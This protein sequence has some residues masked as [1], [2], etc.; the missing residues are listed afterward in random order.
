MT[1]DKPTIGHVSWSPDYDKDWMERQMEST[2]LQGLLAAPDAAVITA[3]DEAN[4]P[5]NRL[6]E[7]EAEIAA[8]DAA[9]ADTGPTIPDDVVG[10]LLAWKGLCEKMAEA[11]RCWKLFMPIGEG[12]TLYSGHPKVMGEEALR[13]YEGWK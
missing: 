7:E 6:K 12:D 2:R 9:M 4:K 5:D 10:E 13:E 1:D 8:F 3:K 11:L